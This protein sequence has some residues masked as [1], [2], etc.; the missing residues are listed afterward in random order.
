LDR[1]TSPGALPPIAGDEKRQYVFSMFGALGPDY[2]RWNRLIS[3]GL[4][5][6]WRRK[7]TALLAECRM[8]CDVG[9]G[10]GD[11][12]RALLSRPGFSGQVLAVDPAPAL[13]RTARNAPLAQ[14]PRCGFAVAEAE[15]LPLA[16]D[17]CDGLM[18]GF[19]MRNFFDFDMAQSECARILRRG[20]VGVFLEMGHPPNPLWARAFKFYFERLAPFVAG[21]FARTPTAYRY[22]PASLERFPLQKEIRNRF[23][24]NGFA[25]AEYKEY[26]GGAIVIYK[27][28]K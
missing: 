7:A 4:D 5:R 20:G 25:E 10:T 18:S 12:A 23:L 15:H 8:V 16:S 6:R 24:T 13:W 1:G 14:H 17:S 3:W 2:D 27:V 28:T 26:L 19:V 9:A 11:M 21:L 22:L